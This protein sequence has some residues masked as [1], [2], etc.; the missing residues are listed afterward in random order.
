MDSISRASDNTSCGSNFFEPHSFR[1]YGNIAKLTRK[2]RI[3][4]KYF[5]IY[6]QRAADAFAERYIK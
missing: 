5:A 6:Y 2:A 4:A 3:A 1:V